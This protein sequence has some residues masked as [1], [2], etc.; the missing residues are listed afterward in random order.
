MTLSAK[1]RGEEIEVY[2]SAESEMT[3]FG[4]PNSPRFEEIRTETIRVDMVEILGVYV[5]M[6]ELPE[7]LQDA[8]CALHTEVDFE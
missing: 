3:D 1:Y 2:F 6:S 7:K 8:I 4:V 5:R